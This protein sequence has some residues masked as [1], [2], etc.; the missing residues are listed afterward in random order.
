VL[1][2]LTEKRACEDED[3]KEKWGVV[4]NVL[5]EVEDDVDDEEVQDYFEFKD[6]FGDVKR[7]QG[8]G[9]FVSQPHCENDFKRDD[10]CLNHTQFLYWVL[11]F[12][13]VDS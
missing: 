1:T 9:C 12:L 3:I 5:I 10:H 7:L 8:F 2:H 4:Q 6:E 13:K 11:Q